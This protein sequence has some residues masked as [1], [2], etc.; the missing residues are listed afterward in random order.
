MSPEHTPP[1]N[2]PFIN[3]GKLEE[4][5]RTLPKIPCDDPRIDEEDNLIP[6][7]PFYGKFF[8][9]FLEIKAVVENTATERQI[10]YIRMVK[11]RFGVDLLSFYADN[12]GLCEAIVQELIAQ[13]PYISLVE[14][15]RKLEAEEAAG[16]IPAESTARINRATGHPLGIKAVGLFYMDMLN[17]LLQQAY[18]LLETQ[19]LNAPFFI[20]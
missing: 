4:L 13:E 15:T 19:T 18:S 7:E 1:R 5:A 3:I 16:I 2:E 10:I 9:R 20:R 14:L 17:P 8:Q 6:S 11:E 12:Q